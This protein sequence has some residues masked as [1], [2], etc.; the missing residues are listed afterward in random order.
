MA[1]FP[2]LRPSGWSY[3]SK[4]KSAEMQAIDEALVK[5]PN[6]VDGSSHIAAALVILGGAGMRF[7]G[8]LE[9]TQ[10]GDITVGASKSITWPNLASLIT[11]AGSVTLLGGNG[12]I[13]GTLTVTGSGK[14]QFESV[15]EVI[16]GGVL[17]VRGDG[18]LIVSGNS[19][20]PAELS[21][22]EYGFISIAASGTLQIEN[23]GVLN[24]E[25]GGSVLVKSGGLFTMR[26]TGN[27]LGAGFGGGSSKLFVQGGG[28][29]AP[30]IV[31]WSGAGDQAIFREE[32]TLTMIATSIVNDGARTTKTGPL[33]LSGDEGVIGLRP[34]NQALS[35]GVTHIDTS[36]KDRFSMPSISV[37]KTIV[38]DDPPDPTI[39]NEARLSRI[40]NTNPFQITVQRSDAT[41]IFVFN[42]SGNEGWVDVLWDTT[43][44]KHHVTAFGGD[45]TLVSP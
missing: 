2:I 31:E 45:V 37:A 17:Y 13:T 25:S 39:A 12:T 15:G 11:Q 34:V 9:A 19:G 14:L 33:I 23:L 27:R 32:S 43:D 44:G 35:G 6:F 42:V 16:A 28:V 4:L 40:R 41:T 10:A 20:H 38:I 3:L 26:G 18:Q 5:V 21:V 30:A 36:T 22:D 24:V 7:T 29:L 1:N 8:T